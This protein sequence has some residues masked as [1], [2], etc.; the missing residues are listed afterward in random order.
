MV[1]VISQ[2]QLAAKKV[3]GWCPGCGVPLVDD[4]IVSFSA[5][6]KRELKWWCNAASNAECYYRCPVC[7]SS[8]WIFAYVHG[9]VV[10]EKYYPHRGV[11]EIIRYMFSIRPSWRQCRAYRMV[12]SGVRW[13]QRASVVIYDELKGAF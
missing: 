7:G 11:L 2:E 10:Y 8:Y 4:G 3:D 9:V 1:W 6:S 12:K 13:G 5:I